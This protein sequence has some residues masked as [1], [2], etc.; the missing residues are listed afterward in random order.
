MADLQTMRQELLGELH[1][2]PDTSDTDSQVTNDVTRAIIESIRYNRRHRFGF[3]ERWGVI[4]L[5][6]SVDTYDLPGDFIGLVPDMVFSVPNDGYLERRKMKSLPLQH[7]H[8]LGQSVI[9][10]PSFREIGT[11]FAY[12]IDAGSRQMIVYPKPLTSSDTIEYMYVADVGTPV[13]KYTGSAWAFYVPPEDGNIANASTTLPATHTSPW[14]QEAYGLVFCRAAYILLTRKYGGIQGSEAKAAQY[15]SQWA[16]N[17]NLLRAET[18]M[19]RSV[20]E[21][22]KHL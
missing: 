12:A 2:D 15:I 20:T 5:T 6:A 22:R 4:V 10:E 13:A 14:F 3:N 17:L 7:A 9:A 21:V 8:Q 16:E 11:P 1:I 19:M 18:R